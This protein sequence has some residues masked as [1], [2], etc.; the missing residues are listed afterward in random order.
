MIIRMM[1]AG[2]GE[3][4]SEQSMPSDDPQFWMYDSAPRFKCMEL[5]LQKGAMLTARQFAK[6]TSILESC[7]GEGVL[8]VGAVLSEIWNC[9][10]R[11]AEWMRLQPPA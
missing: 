8:Q 4:E 6:L 5:L 9:T 11:R 2:D 7:S 1:D 10:L 3:G